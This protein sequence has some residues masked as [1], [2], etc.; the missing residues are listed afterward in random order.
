MTVSLVEKGYTMIVDKPLSELE[1]YHPPLTTAHDFNDFWS[2]TLAESATQPLNSTSEEYTFPSDR[3]TVYQV[4]YD[5]FGQGTRIAGWYLLPRENYRIIDNGKTPTLV[6]YHGY[7]GS[8]NLPVSYMA[9]AL[10]GYGVFAVDTRGQNGE[11]PDNNAYSSGSVL[12]CMT[13]GILDPY[14]YYYRY[15]YMDCVRAIDF[16]RSRPEVGAII[17][18]GASQGGGLTLAVAALAR[19]KGIVAAMPDVPFLS[20]FRR[21]VEMFTEGPYRE[22]VDYW[23]S[24]PYDVEASYRTLSYF[25]GMNLAPRINCPLLLSVALLDT[26]CPPSTGFAVYNHLA[27]EK[28]IKVYPYNGHEGGS[29][30]HEVEK[31]SFVREILKQHTP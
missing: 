26:I 22:L 15:A 10:A 21:S 23:K 20:H 2:E 30:F 5:G 28:T 1:H 13:K 29:E 7:S 9:W 14:G 31:Y 3:V 19:D 17:P 16:L 12:G 18:T 6:Y 27:C 25:D 24:H 8:K 11:T 4:R